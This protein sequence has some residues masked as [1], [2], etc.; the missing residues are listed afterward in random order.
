[1]STLQEIKAAIAHLQPRERALLTAELLAAEPERV[2]TA[3]ALAAR[4]RIA[5]PTASKLLKQLHRAALC[6]AESTNDLS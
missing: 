5:A 1:M 4:T 3:T 6:N 2:H